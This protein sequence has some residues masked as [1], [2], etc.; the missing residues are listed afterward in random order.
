MENLFDLSQTELFKKLQ[1][2]DQGHVSSDIPKLLA[3]YGHNDIKSHEEKSPILVLLFK[4]ANPLVIMLFVVAIFSIFFGEKISAIIIIVMALMGVILS[5]IQEHQSSKNA[6]KLQ[7]MVKVSVEVLRDGKIIQ[8]PLREIVP[9]D[10]IQLSAGKMIPADLKIIESTDLFINQSVLNGESFPVRKIAEKASAPESTDSIFNHPNLVF[11]GSSVASGE[12]KGL[13]VYTGKETEFGQLAKELAHSKEETAFDKG[14]K[15]FVWL[16]IR[17]IFVLTLSIFLINAISKGNYIES[18][19]FALAVAVGLTP[20][21]LPAIITVN[22]SKGALVMAKKKVIVKE[23]DSIQ[24][25]GAMDILCT[26]KTGTLTKNDISVVDYCDFSGNKNEDVIKNAYYTSFFQTGLEG[27]LESAVKNYK[28]FPIDNIKKANE[29]PFDFERRLMSVIINDKKLKLITKGAPEEILKR[30]KFYQDGEKS[31]PINPKIL[32]QIKKK[33]EDLSR[34]GYRVLGI[35]TKEVSKKPHYSHEEESEMTFLG[36]IAFLD[37]PKP[38]AEKSIKQ[39]NNL[40]ISLKILSGDNALVTEKVCREVGL[41]ITGLLTGEEVDKLNE[42]ELRNKAEKTNV[43]ARLS[44]MQ[45]ERV[46][47]ALQES[48]HIVGYLGDGINDSPAI[49]KADVGISVNNATDIAKETANLILLEKDLTILSDCVK[50]GRRVFANVIKYIKMGSSS[51]FGNMVSMTAASFFLPFLPMLP[52]QI[53]LNNFM[54]DISQLAIPTDKVDK[55]YLLTPRPWHIKFIRE[56]IIYL[57]PISSIFDF[58]T[59]GVMWYFFHANAHLFQTGWFVESLTTQVLVVFI[60]RTNKIPFFQ[61]WPSK[62][63]L[64]TTLSIVGLGFILPYLPAVSH[65]MGFQ[66]LPAV[67]FLILL[68]IAI[69]YLLLVQFAKNIFIKKFGYE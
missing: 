4:F 61:S 14:I 47:R 58:I 62:A 54:Y 69:T 42:D 2:S 36:L 32:N 5:F 17:L 59:F 24:N 49:K 38:D 13:V 1:T 34:D 53:L 21:M 45:K 20:E 35:A 18:L 28:K 37:P 6:Q 66:P 33:Y 3:E 23:L 9:G 56:F 60:I 52:T 40:G 25:F 55:D 19:L 10:I 8:V 39:L 41:E 7:E 64:A 48:K 67:F 43:F 46:I 63:L 12:G 26:D 30:S 31:L 44:P 65:L 51:N 27:V 22:L 68:G 29:I 11:M 50:E 57:G 16:M 15:G